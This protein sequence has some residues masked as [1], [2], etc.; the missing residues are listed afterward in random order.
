MKN[1]LEENITYTS[2][3]QRKAKIYYQSCLDKN[4]TIEK[5]SSKPMLDFIEVVSR[6]NFK[7]FK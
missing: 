6:M 3:A 7:K 4:E 1:V 2:D 5:L